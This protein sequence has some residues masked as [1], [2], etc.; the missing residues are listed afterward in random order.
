MQQDLALAAALGLAHVERN[1]HH[2]ARGMSAAPAAEQQAF[3]RA[4]PDLYDLRDGTAML[5]I[6]DGA[7]QIGSLDAW[8]ITPIR[9]AAASVP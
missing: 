4:H 5:R 1:G 7:I 2:Y 3:A 6:R 9:S 8:T